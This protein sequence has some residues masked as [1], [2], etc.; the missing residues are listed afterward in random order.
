M[1][2]DEG[3]MAESASAGQ[4]RPLLNTGLALTTVAYLL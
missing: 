1:Q 2:V 4:R 3:R